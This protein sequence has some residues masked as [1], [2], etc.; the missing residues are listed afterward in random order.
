MPKTNIRKFRLYVLIEQIWIPLAS[1]YV[2]RSLR[3]ANVIHTQAAI[4]KTM[5]L[6]NVLPFTENGWMM[7]IEAATTPI[8]NV[9]APN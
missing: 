3:N 1:K 2:N 8:I 7:I 4:K 5:S 9:A 6:M